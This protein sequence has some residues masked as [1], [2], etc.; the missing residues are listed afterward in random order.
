MAYDC[1]LLSSC[2]PE[3]TFQT[4]KNKYERSLLHLNRRVFCHHLTFSSSN[5]EMTKIGNYSVLSLQCSDAVL[6]ADDQHRE[7]EN[8]KQNC[9]TV[10]KP[11]AIDA[12]RLKTIELISI[13]DSVQNGFLHCAVWHDVKSQTVN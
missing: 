2:F 12:T 10:F 13:S 8:I 7:R 4:L 1:R 5:A 11:E 9:H 6:T 3:L